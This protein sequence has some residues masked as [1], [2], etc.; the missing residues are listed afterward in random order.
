MVEVGRRFELAGRAAV[1]NRFE[2]AAFEAAEIEEAFADD[3]PNA[4]LP[5]EGP[6]AHIPGAA[7]AFAATNLPELRRAA[8]RRDS[9]AFA[10]AFARAADMCNACHTASEK[11]FIQVPRLPGRPVPD[12]ELPPTVPPPSR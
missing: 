8:D 12:L 11:P 4:Q 6:T 1:A 5:K 2:L 7:K 3:L 10:E 9:S